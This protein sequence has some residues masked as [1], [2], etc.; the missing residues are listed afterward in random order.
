MG[1]ADGTVVGMQ[2]VAQHGRTDLLLNLVLVAEGFRADELPQ[3]SQYARRFVGRLLSFSPFDEAHC[4]INVFQIDV[5]SA[6]SGADDP[7]ECGGSGANVA[8]YFDASFCHGGV[9][10]AISVD[11]GS[12]IDVVRMFVAQWHLILIV[13]NSTKWGGTGGTIAKTSVAPE[14]EDVALHEM[15]HSLFGLADEYEYL[16]G[17]STDTDRD[18]WPSFLGIR[19]EPGEPNITIQ[20]ER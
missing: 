7:A 5:S 13:V 16:L 9:P 6:E 2:P 14:W 11:E 1:T 15:G 4:G 8:T 10:R 12:V 20:T 19:V 17:C 3:S 18:E